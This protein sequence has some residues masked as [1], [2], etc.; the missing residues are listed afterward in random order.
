[1][2]KIH[3]K[4]GKRIQN[5]DPFDWMLQQMANERNDEGLL[6]DKLNMTDIS[7]HAIVLMWRKTGHKQIPASALEMLNVPIDD[8]IA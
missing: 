5:G 6:S 1:M 3:T 8:I 7:R 4:Q 2:K